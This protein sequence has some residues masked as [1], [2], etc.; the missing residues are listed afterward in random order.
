MRQ[1]RNT[2]K[3]FKLFC[4]DTEDHYISLELLNAPRYLKPNPV[5]NAMEAKVVL[6]LVFL[7]A[8]Y[9]S[10]VKTFI[11]DMNIFVFHFYLGSI[12]AMNALQINL[13]TSYIYI[14][15]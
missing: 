13:F 2:C 11:P 6:H 15:L 8:K 12:C 7:L 14:Q 1:F 4:F 5:G 10:P 3:F 9:C